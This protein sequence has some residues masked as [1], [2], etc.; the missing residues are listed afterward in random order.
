[1]HRR[2]PIE[3]SNTSDDILDNHRNFHAFTGVAPLKPC[4]RSTT[5]MATYV[6]PRLHRRGPIEAGVWQCYGVWQCSA[7]HAFTGVA[8][9][10]RGEDFVEGVHFHLISTPSQ[11]WPH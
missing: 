7:F 4:S 5:G 2:G 6:F 11:A 1:L 8:P 10:K 9:L 3:A